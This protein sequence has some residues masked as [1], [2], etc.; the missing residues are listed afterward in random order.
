MIE[1]MDA[2]KS[3]HL[4]AN[5]TDIVTNDDTE[6]F[7]QKS[8]EARDFSKE[9]GY[10]TTVKFLKMLPRQTSG[11]EALDKDETLWQ[12]NWVRV[13]E[14]TSGET[15]L[16]SDGKRIWFQVT[17]RDGT[18]HHTLFIN[19]GA[20]LQLSGINQAE[21]FINAY[22]SGRLWF[23]L[24]CSLKVLR[25]RSANKADTGLVG[26]VK[27]D[28]VDAVKPDQKSNFDMYIVE[29]AEQN[30]KE[31]PTKESLTFSHLLASTMD[32]VDVFLP[33]ALHMIRKSVHYS[34]MVNYVPQNLLPEHAKDLVAHAGG[35]TL[36]RACYQAFALVESTSPSELIP[37]GDE[38]YKLIT[39]GVKDL[40]APKVTATY[41]LTAFCTLSNLQ[42]FKLDPP[43]GK[44]KQAAIIIISDVSP[45][46][47]ADDPINF[48]VDSIM[49]LP[50]DDINAISAAM[51]QLLYFMAAATE[52]NEHKRERDLKWDAEHS[53]AKAF[54]CRVLSRY[55]TGDP[56]PEYQGTA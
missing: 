31:A 52:V 45:G 8:I 22:T 56:L 16:T 55:P 2:P 1:A 35:V 4:K 9:N 10:E 15:I 13:H 24:I 23:P 26:A 21:E 39:K 54:K 19:E 30:L 53:P 49:L 50:G 25:K 7:D 5:A 3:Q 41:T 46:T 28:M 43:R 48:I 36:S 17:F 37:I 38:G 18:H 14:P 32:S 20:A 29:A 27:P 6:A 51:N 40:L 42:D 44:K 12:T 11:I 34:M 33:A 47:K